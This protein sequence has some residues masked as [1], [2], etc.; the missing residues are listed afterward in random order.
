ML[1][2]IFHASKDKYCCSCDHVVQIIPKV[3]LK[4]VPHLSQKV[5]GMLNY[6][7]KS[8]PVIDF[9]VLM[10]GDP[11]KNS[12]HTRIIILNNPNLKSSVDTLAIL[13][14][15]VIETKE[16]DVNQFIESGLKVE[17][18]SYLDGIFNKNGESIQQILV[19]KFFEYTEKN[20]G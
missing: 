16:L 10:G 17:D 6:A 13:A 20:Y 19:D 4:I 12:M 11:C 2:L 14:E 7:G 1:M 8:I 5:A 9:S 18:A 3:T 15:K